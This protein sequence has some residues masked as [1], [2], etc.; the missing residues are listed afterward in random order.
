M[1]VSPLTAHKCFP[2]W[3]K[4]FAKSFLERAIHEPAESNLHTLSEL[5]SYTVAMNDIMFWTE[6]THSI[7]SVSEYTIHHNQ[8]T[9]AL[10]RT[11]VD[12][13][14]NPGGTDVFLCVCA[15]SASSRCFQQLL[16]SW[17]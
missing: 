13:I 5:L 7:Y 16:Q 14:F 10:K 11:R 6:F 4:F 1:Q 15:P 17:I 3:H 9:G 8:Y 2:K 12:Y